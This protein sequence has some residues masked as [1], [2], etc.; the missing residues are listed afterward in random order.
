MSKLIYLTTNKFKMKEA[1]YFFS[2]KY[3]FE[4][5][6]MDPSF[7][8]PEIQA[9]NCLDVV[10]FSVK[11][12]AERMGVPV[13]KSDSGLYIDCLGGLPGPYNAYFDKQIGIEKFLK[14]LSGEDNRNARLEHTYA[15]CEPGQE[16]IVFSGGSHGQISMIAKGNPELGRWH[17]MFFIPNG[18]T[19]TL[20]E[21]REENPEYESTF[22][23]TAADDFAHWYI[24]NK[25]D[26]K[27]VVLGGK[28]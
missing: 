17:D 13:L 10:K 28:K 14:L 5:Q 18:E 26:V 23:G 19:K 15:Y 3:G 9:N 8:I 7:E 12:A 24:N 20:C 22:W 6:I 25:I 21:L 2:T 4:L 11:Y 27:K 16:P 1:N